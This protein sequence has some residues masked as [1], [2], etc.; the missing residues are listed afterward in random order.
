M[1]VKEI[2]DKVG[3]LRRNN[4]FTIEDKMRWLNQ[5]EAMVQLECLLLPKVE[6][7]YDYTIDENERLIAK[8]PY[9]ELYVHYV[10]AKIDEALGEMAV[11]NDD[12]KLFNKVNGDYRRWLIKNYNPAFN[13]IILK[14]DDPVV[15][16]GYELTV[17][18][19][20]L[21]LDAKNITES[22]GTLTQ[23]DKT[24]EFTEVEIVGDVMTFTVPAEESGKLTEGT[25]YAGYDISDGE[26]RL[27]EQKAMRIYVQAAPKAQGTVASQAQ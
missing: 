25:L 12:I 7:T 27:Y 19:Y 24:T 9:D 11:Y 26:N 15:I 2:I 23:G 20:G 16:R 6:V 10:C 4:Q 22:K 17:T 13:K 5:C 21:P 18:L 3:T 1:T 14:R 8:P